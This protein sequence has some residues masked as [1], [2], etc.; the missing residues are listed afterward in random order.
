MN[1]SYFASPKIFKKDYNLISISRK[2]PVWFN[3][4]YKAYVQLCPSWDLVMSYKS[5]KITKEEYTIRYYDEVL[6]K[7]DPAR[8]YQE[9]G[10]N[11][12]L[13]CWERAKEF[14]HRRIVA[15]WFL[16]H[17]QIEVKEL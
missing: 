17:L 12:I 13:L 8:T 4:P 7:L 16:K 14:C 10:E 15:D 11:A 6:N 2:P 1:T 3:E 5:D 9:L